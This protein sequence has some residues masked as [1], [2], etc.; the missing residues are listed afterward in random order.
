M[1][2]KIKATDYINTGEPV[3]L[4]KNREVHALRHD[5]SKKARLFRWTGRLIH[6][7]QLSNYGY[8]Q[9]FIVGTALGD[10][11]YDDKKGCHFTTITLHR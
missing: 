9:S 11:V 5:F 8:G 6:N 1:E 10:S 7:Q 3:T 2:T 4:N